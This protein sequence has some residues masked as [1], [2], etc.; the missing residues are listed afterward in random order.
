MKNNFKKFFAVIAI[1]A[2]TIGTITVISSVEA[3]K[4]Y[5]KKPAT[6]M[7]VGTSQTLKTDKN[8]NYP[9]KSSNKKILTVT[10][11]G[12]IKAVKKGTAKIT[13]TS[14]KNKKSKLTYTIKVQAGIGLG[15][16]K[17]TSFK[18]DVLTLKKGSKT[19]MVLADVTSKD[20]YSLWIKKYEICSQKDKANGSFVLTARKVG[21]TK[22]EIT[23]NRKGQLGAATRTITIKVVSALPDVDSTEVVKPTTE[24][25]KTTT[26]EPTTEATTTEAPAPN[27]NT[28][29]H[30]W[31]EIKGTVKETRWVNEAPYFMEEVG[32]LRTP[33][34]TI[35]NTCGFDFTMNNDGSE[36]SHYRSKYA[37]DHVS[38]GTQ[39]IWY[40]E[41]YITPIMYQKKV[42]DSV[43]YVGRKCNVCGKQE[44]YM[45]G[46]GKYRSANNDGYVDPV[47]CS[48]DFSVPHYTV[49]EHGKYYWIPKMEDDGCWY[50]TSDGVTIET[51]GI[52]KMYYDN[53]PNA[54]IQTGYECSKCHKA[55]KYYTNMKYNPVQGDLGSDFKDFGVFNFNGVSD[56]WGNP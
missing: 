19:T 7:Y 14:K 29:S 51:N 8:S 4:A 38:E 36:N 30:Q 20:D 15:F 41:Y 43:Y 31:V 45:V 52:S 35:C 26:E 37:L 47:T 25:Q 13:I 12:V 21:T 9:Y 53:Q 23:V 10:K 34:H 46:D 11:A 5:V 17:G 27:Q 54:S 33:S 3:S 6:L 2:I 48:H 28:C 55:V 24:E 42:V 56:D 22:A 32:C 40:G 18:N 50:A 16:T 1:I 44:N 49:I 39:P